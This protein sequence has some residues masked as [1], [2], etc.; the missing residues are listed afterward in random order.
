MACKIC[1][2]SIDEGEIVILTEKGA[3][4]VNNVNTLRNADVHVIPDDEV[5]T[6]C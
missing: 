6:K 3:K 2:K 1:L 5:H 4:G